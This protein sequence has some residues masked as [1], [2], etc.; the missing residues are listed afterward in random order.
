LCSKSTDIELTRIGI[1]LKAAVEQF[2]E[3][4]QNVE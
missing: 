1:A 4:A 3:Q 2:R